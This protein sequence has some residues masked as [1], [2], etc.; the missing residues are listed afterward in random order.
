MKKFEMNY[1]EQQDLLKEK[2]KEFETINKGLRFQKIN[3]YSNIYD[4][5]IDESQFCEIEKVNIEYV[6]GSN[7]TFPTFRI[8]YL[9]KYYDSAL[10]KKI[11][12]KTGRDLYQATF[13]ESFTVSNDFCTIKLL[14]KVQEKFDNWFYIVETTK[15]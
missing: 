11:L 4:F 6:E 3:I 8:E 10:T 15:R 1:I 7:H 13:I 2:I 5:F 14:K 9:I 12:E